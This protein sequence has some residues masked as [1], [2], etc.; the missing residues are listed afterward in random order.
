MADKMHAMN[1]L[2]AT[3]VILSVL[4][5]WLGV[6]QAATTLLPNGKQ[7]FSNANGP[8]SS[9]S[10]NM[11]TPNTTTPKTTWLDPNQQAANTQ[12][13]QLDA[14]GCAVIYGVGTYR[15]QVYDGPVVL[16]VTTGN[17]V[18]DQLTTDT[19]AGQSVWG[20]Y[21]GLAGGTA[22][23]IVLTAP[24]FTLTDG[25]I[26]SFRVLA[27]NTSTTTINPGTGAIN[28]VH[29][30][31]TGSASLTGGEFVAT[32][33]AAVQYDASNNQFHVVSPVFWP[34]SNTVPVGAVFPF[35]GFTP[36]ANYVLAQGQCVS[37]STFGAL[38]GAYT[39][40]EVGTTS[41]GNSTITGLADTS[42]FYNGQPIEGTGIA[43]SSTVV[44][45]TSST[46]TMNQNASGSGTNNITFFA[47]SNCDG[48]TTFGLPDYRGFVLAGR[49]TPG[50]P[51]N[52]M[53]VATTITTSNGSATTT[54]GSA[55]GLSIGMVVVT[56]N[57]P[58]GYTIS[59][60]SG[61]T[62][63]L[64]SGTNVTSGSGVAARFGFTTDAQGLGA[65]G[66]S[67]THSQLASEIAT[68]TTTGTINITDPGH[69][70]TS[71]TMNSTPGTFSA[72]GNT[73]LLSGTGGVTTG[74]S[75][76]NSTTGLNSGNV[77]FTGN[78]TGSSLPAST[79]Q[80]TKNVNYIVRLTP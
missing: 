3:L 47:Y 44:S 57:V 28:V 1:K 77:T 34:S 26:I 40:T 50:A 29:D 8:L 2:V 73:V 22:N 27:T 21:A 68:H 5:G 43:A 14:A 32:N 24:S 59:N 30:L 75:T 12:P 7:C 53:Q 6:A 16:G 64:S 79:Q 33:V 36:P 54:V 4:S 31:S 9:G 63:T 37:R 23:N 38:F 72:G 51:A 69:T 49:D 42:Q 35:P 61:T 18:W 78:P 67:I 58:A 52:N 60:I 46:V 20:I 55:T 70:H 71:T 41:S 48:S 66:G 74:G 15:Q 80:P 62:V 39:L 17:L 56:A 45:V 76:N 65:K 19:S 11:Y 25:Q 10:V 13:I